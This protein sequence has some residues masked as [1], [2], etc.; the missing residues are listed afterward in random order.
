MLKKIT[1]WFKKEKT[2]ECIVFDG[3]KMSYPSLTQKQI[4]DINTLP[5][6]KHWKVQ[7]K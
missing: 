1:A 6:Y 4:D 7:L 2:Y 5:Q 3:K